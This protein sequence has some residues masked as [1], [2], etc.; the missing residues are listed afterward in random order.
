MVKL[1]TTITL[2]LSLLSFTPTMA[3]EDKEANTDQAKYFPIEEPFTINF[4]NQSDNK[5]RYLQIKVALMSH[6]DSVINSAELNLPMIQDA[7]R[8]LFTDQDYQTV[9]TIA[10]RQQLQLAALNM[11]QSLLK[12]ETGRGGLD[13]FYFTSFILQ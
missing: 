10:G 7:L 5:V 2:V 1:L 12:E 8:N 4:Q 11:V 3:A 13:Q 9:S 6:Q